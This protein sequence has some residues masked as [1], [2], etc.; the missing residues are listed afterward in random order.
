MTWLVL[1]LTVSY[2]ISAACSKED[3]WFLLEDS[4]DD[5]ILNANET[6]ADILA[7]RD[8]LLHEDNKNVTQ[9]ER[10]IFFAHEQSEVDIVLDR[11]F[12][13]AEA[14]SP[15]SVFP[16]VQG[17]LDLMKPDG[18][19][20]D[21]TYAN[22]A[23]LGSRPFTTHGDRLKTLA[24]S[25]HIGNTKNPWF[26]KQV[27]VER[28]KLSLQY[29]ASEA[30]VNTDWNWHGRK[31]AVPSALW[32]PLVLIRGKISQSL[33]LAILNKYWRDQSVWII[34]EKS[35]SLGGGNLASRARLS[36]VE[37]AL[38]R[39][40]RPR[41]NEIVREL[42]REILHRAGRSGSGLQ[43]D[44]CGTQH[45]I[46]A[47]RYGGGDLRHTARQIYVGKYN[48]GF[49]E[50]VS[51]MMVVLRATSYKFSSETVN[52]L[53]NA[54][55]DSQQY[56]MRSR[57]FEPTTCGRD[58][59]NNRR[60]TEWAASSYVYKSAIHF[61]LLGFIPKEVKTELSKVVR[62]W[63][64]KGPDKSSELRGNRAFFSTDMMVHQ[65]LGYMA[66]VRMTSERTV[67]PETWVGK[68]TAN[69]D[70]YFLGDGFT[71]LIRDGHEFGTLNN[72][73]F[74]F[75][76][77]RKLPGVTAEI[78]GTIPRIHH[79]G[80]ANGPTK[81]F[82][83]QTNFASFVGGVSDGFYGAAAMVYNRPTVRVKGKKAWFF[84]DDEFV[85]LGADIHIPNT[86]SGK[87][88]VTS[89]TQNLQRGVMTAAETD[90]TW[91][92]FSTPGVRSFH[93]PRWIYH[94]STGYFFLERPQQLTL[95]VS[96]KTKD[97]KS[98]TLFTSWLDHGNQPKA[99]SYAYVTKPGITRDSALTQYHANMPVQVNAFNCLQ[100]PDP[101][102]YLLSIL[103]VCMSM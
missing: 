13:L 33:I 68:R 63:E 100:L 66:A 22:N 2:G 76:D 10:S 61:S 39:E 1:L 14:S 11:L 95:D 42:E 21:L 45:N 12:T 78:T 58:I 83:H 67:R 43:A 65:R 80:N 16:K 77:W 26:K 59:T 27:L 49:Y 88:I 47:G 73:V 44:N 91:V 55:L 72:E 64:N 24:Q 62:R 81:N 50:L 19:F 71:T 53:V 30:P 31:V 17:V 23:E 15:D 69:P 86:S 32:V 20:R 96:S 4:E 56:F 48:G 51:Q 98:L 38:R 101:Y 5:Y 75:Y 3:D 9:R 7:Y 54:F 18:S 89:L 70:G 8:K 82:P 46:V 94:D 60:V 29:L 25:Y 103:Y 36:L 41:R 57:V 74:R 84:F 79:G 102:E 35:E 90:G 93:S 6:E 28:I 99:A 92:T 52:T 97:G 85:S 40:L 37:A 87:K 34:T